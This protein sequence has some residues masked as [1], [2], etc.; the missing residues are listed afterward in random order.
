VAEIYD[1]TYR[2]QFEPSVLDPIV[3]LLAGGIRLR[4]HT[5]GC[6]AVLGQL[7]QGR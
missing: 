6:G 4:R 2:A 7:T 3:D 5:F 1:Q